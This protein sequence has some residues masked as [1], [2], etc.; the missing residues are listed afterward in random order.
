MSNHQNMI[1]TN[2]HEEN[3]NTLGLSTLQR[4]EGVDVGVAR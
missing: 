4:K 2:E 3:V 1:I